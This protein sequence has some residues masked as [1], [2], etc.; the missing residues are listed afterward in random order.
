M[1]HIS[2]NIL[3][4]LFKSLVS[5]CFYQIDYEINDHLQN[6]Y[7]KNFVLRMIESTKPRCS[8]IESKSRSISKYQVLHFWRTE[9][10]KN[11]YI[12]MNVTKIPWNG[13]SSIESNQ[14][15]SKHQMLG[16]REIEQ[17]KIF[18]YVFQV[19]HSFL[20]SHLSLNLY[21]II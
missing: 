3:A 8:N 11:D 14:D 21:Q 13:C 5:T 16:F 10:Q 1:T 19:L 15:L 17:Q 12:P 2:I 4:Y 6:Q 18:H 7:I 9:Q 20:T